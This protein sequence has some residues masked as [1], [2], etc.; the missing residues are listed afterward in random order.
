M[1]F[2]IAVPSILCAAIDKRLVW[3]E[4]L[5]RGENEIARQEERV[6]DAADEEHGKE[7]ECEKAQTRIDLCGFRRRL[8]NLSIR[9]IALSRRSGYPTLFG[10]FKDGDDKIR[11]LYTQ[12]P[13]V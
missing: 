11:T 8:P 9:L 10:F 3:N 12:R 7:G 5:E 1:Y 2:A 6:E 4:R 13:V